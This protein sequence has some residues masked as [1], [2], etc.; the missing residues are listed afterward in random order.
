MGPILDYRFNKDF[1]VGATILNL[2]EIPYTQKVN[3][4]NEPINNVIWDNSS[5]KK[6][7]P[8]V[9]KIV[10]L[11]P[12]YSTTAKSFLQADAEFA[13]FIPGHAS[14]IGTEGVT[15][16]DDFEG[17]KST[18]DLK[19]SNFWFMASTPQGQP[20]WFKEALPSCKRCTGQ[21]K[22]SLWFQ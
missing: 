10:D 5:Y 9:T 18:V 14:V 13:Q 1:N 2:R 12:F 3:Y 8:I 17:S 7:L 22:I 4:G 6:E 15:Y 19:S 16:I 21:K 20:D 11:L